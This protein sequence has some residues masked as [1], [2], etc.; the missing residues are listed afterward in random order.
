[1]SLLSSI[2]R[3][4]TGRGVGENIGG[5]IGQSL[6]GPSGAMIGS[7]VGGEISAQLSRSSKENLGQNVA[8][9]RAMESQSLETA[10]TGAMGGTYSSPNI[11]NA[12]F[13]PPNMP[14]ST[15]N[16]GFQS[17]NVLPFIMQQGTRALAALGAIDLFYNDPVT[18]EMKRKRITR[19]FKSQVKQSVELVGLEETARMLGTEPEI[20]V[21]I[22][23]KRFRN[24]G[25]VVTKA[26]VRKT[27]STVRKMKAICDMYDSL[28]PPARRATGAARARKSTSTTLIKN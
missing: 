10:D 6:G 11:S 4:A 28:R 3:R 22:L 19:K 16:S 7:S 23:L 8:V 17:A 13:N 14:I 25:P 12:I 18:G 2:V 15:A 20:V 21:Q 24:D 1:M 9:S 26:A 5:F 27:K